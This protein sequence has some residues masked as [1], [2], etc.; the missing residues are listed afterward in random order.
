VRIPVKPAGCHARK[1]ANQKG[2]KPPAAKILS[3]GSAIFI[4]S[5]FAAFLIAAFHAGVT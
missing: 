1:S 3:S 2:P 5:G 4:L